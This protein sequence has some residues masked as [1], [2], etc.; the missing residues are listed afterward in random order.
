MHDNVNG[1]HTPISIISKLK[2]RN[3]AKDYIV[4]VA[5]HFFN[6][7]RKAKLPSDS[8]SKKIAINLLENIENEFTNLINEIDT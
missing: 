4:R 3:E 2:K 5:W 8:F 7:S 6:N 1:S